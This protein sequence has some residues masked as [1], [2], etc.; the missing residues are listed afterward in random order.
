MA[1]FPQL[2]VCGGEGL[3]GL[4]EDSD[5]LFP[6][7]SQVGPVSTYHPQVIPSILHLPQCGNE[8]ILSNAGRTR[9]RWPQAPAAP[10]VKWAWHGSAKLRRQDWEEA[11]SLSH[12]QM[13]NERIQKHG[14]EVGGVFSSIRPQGWPQFTELLPTGALSLAGPMAPCLLPRPVSFLHFSPSWP[15]A[16]VPGAR[17]VT[18]HWGPL[19]TL[20]WGSRFNSAPVG[21]WA[22]GDASSTGSVQ[23]V[24]PVGL[25]P[26]QSSLF[27]PVQPVRTH[28]SLLRAQRP[29]GY[30]RGG[31][32]TGTP[33]T[34]L[35]GS[36]QGRSETLASL[37]CRTEVGRRSL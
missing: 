14:Q 21:L 4:G 28:I 25:T 18:W 2:S 13:E 10:F 32:P 17:P 20:P 23:W 15:P 24:Q 1:K 30:T 8:L 27:C 9:T 19:G 22:P 31:S 36:P 29:S 6:N 26:S 7:L 3:P 33:S 16:R 34:D 35:P 37:W 5:P 11:L 12:L